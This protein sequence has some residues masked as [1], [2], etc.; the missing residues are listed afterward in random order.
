MIF[1]KYEPYCWL[2]AALHKNKNKD[3]F[4]HDIEH[5]WMQFRYYSI[6]CMYMYMYQYTISITPQSWQYER[7]LLCTSHDTILYMYIHVHTH[8][9]QIKDIPVRVSTIKYVYNY[10]C[11]CDVL[12]LYT[13]NSEKQCY[14]M[15]MEVHVYYIHDY[16]IMCTVPY[17]G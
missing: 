1:I 10:I 14:Y 9:G 6:T 8:R 15:Y 12:K 4:L 16:I 2:H 3:K 5:V 13:A 17:N 7:W 11:T